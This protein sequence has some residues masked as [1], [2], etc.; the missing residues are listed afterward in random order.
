MHGRLVLAHG[1]PQPAYWSQNIW[2]NPAIIPIKSI[3]DA[4]SILRSMGRNW[5]PYKHSFF[6]RMEL[7]QKKLPYISAKPIDFLSPLLPPLC[8]WT[9]L[10][11]N[12]ML[13]AS[14][15]QSPMPNG[16]WNFNED[17]LTPPSRA[18]LKLWELFTRCGF[19]PNKDDI[20]LDLGAC[21]GGWTW[22]LSKLAHSVIAFDKSPLAKSIMDLKNVHFLK[23]DAFK[24]DLNDY[25]KATWVFSDVICYPDKLFKF[26]SHLLENFPDKKYVFTI[27][28]QGDDHKDIIENFAS[29]PGTIVHLSQ[30]KHELTWFKV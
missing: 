22:V 24:V 14:H 1:D 9:L 16:Q 11:P 8:S 28:F 20:C 4:A 6:R 17:K 10:D 19:H 25:P 21:P 30:N 2:Y 5:W 3:G 26:I 29:L 15:C 7:I 27:K 12:T 23:C 18:Y 13:A